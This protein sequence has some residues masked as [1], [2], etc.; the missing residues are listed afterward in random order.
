M[1][2]LAK[3]YLKKAAEEP[4]GIPLPLPS[5]CR[6]IQK[7]TIA[8]QEASHTDFPVPISPEVGRWVLN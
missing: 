2:Q 7:P 5:T 4:K 3:G 6:L 1:H 8:T